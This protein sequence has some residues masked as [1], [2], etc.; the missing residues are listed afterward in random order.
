MTTH[1]T[2]F[3]SDSQIKTVVLVFT[4]SHSQLRATCGQ[5]PGVKAELTATGNKLIAESSRDRFY[6]IGLP[7]QSPTFSNFWSVNLS[8]IS[9]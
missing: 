1:P 8:H 3:T 9:P 4:R 7:I 2:T 6:A 5:H